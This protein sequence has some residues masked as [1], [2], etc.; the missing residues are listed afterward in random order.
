[1]TSF[2]HPFAEMSKAQHNPFIVDRGEG[3]YVYDETGKRYLDA[4]ASLWYMNVGYGREEIVDAMAEQMRK[5]PVFHAFVDYA[6]RPPMELAAQ[7]AA[8]SPDPD[9]KVFFGSGGSDAVDT[10]AKLARRYFGVIGQ[11][12]RTVFIAREWAYH[13]MHSYGT[14]LGGMEPNRLGY[15]GELVSDVVLVPYDDSEAVEKAIDHA[16]ADRV[17]GIFVEAVIGAGGIRPVSPE[18]L[19]SVRETIRAAGALYISDEV[20][21][22]FGRVGDWFA[23]NLYDLEPDLITFAKGVTCGYAPLGGVVVAPHIAEPFFNTPGLVFRHG[24]TYSGHTAACAAG[25]TVMDIIQREGLI[26]RA[27][28]LEDEIYNALLPLEELEVVAKIRRGVGA[29]AAIQLEVGDDETMP[30]RA[31]EVCRSAGVLTRAVGGGALQVSPPLIMT[32]DQ[33]DEMASLFGA[34]LRSL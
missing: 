4:A 25:L 14:A 29:L 3:I 2:W 16:G 1:M 18:Y 7:I 5:L 6:T 28:D 27:K 26:Q 24:Y 33:V 9:S 15:G 13:G 31:A 17:A 10:A 30:Y 34:G 11:P 21:T 12:E 23:A 8:V 32:S 20:I 22:G 19:S